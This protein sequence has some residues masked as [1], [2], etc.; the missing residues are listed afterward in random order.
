S[1]SGGSGGEDE[2]ESSKAEVSD[3][4]E[5]NPRDS[6][7]GGG[8]GVPDAV[9]RRGPASSTPRAPRHGRS[10][11]SS[12]RPQAP[13]PRQPGAEEQVQEVVAEHRGRGRPWKHPVVKGPASGGS[14]RSRGG[15]GAGAG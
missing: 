6:S 3:G 15:A 5:D 1:D 10:H 4:G 12:S 9:S 7:D 14:G 2:E 13:A 8:G 11:L